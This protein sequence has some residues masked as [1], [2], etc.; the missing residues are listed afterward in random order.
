[1]NGAWY[2]LTREGDEGPYPTRAAAERETRRFTMEVTTLSG[3]QESRGAPRVAPV[4]TI[5]HQRFNE[6]AE[7]A[8]PRSDRVLDVQ[9]QAEPRRDLILDLVEYVAPQA[10]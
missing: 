6:L 10:G 4:K 1:M 9:D 7:T 8:A 5:R 2:F 3:F